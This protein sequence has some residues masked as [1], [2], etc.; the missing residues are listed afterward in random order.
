MNIHFLYRPE[1]IELFSQKRYIL[2]LVLYPTVQVVI[3]FFMSIYFT[4][5][6]DWQGLKLV[7]DAMHERY[8]RTV[9]RGDTRQRNTP[10]QTSV[11]VLFVYLPYSAVIFFP[12]F[13]LPDCHM[14][15]L[16]PVLTSIFPA[17]DALVIILLI[18][19]K[20][21]GVLRLV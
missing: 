3:W 20:S 1:K 15:E 5:T 16:F 18:K 11:P 9:V 13:G 2:L 6:D 19:V 10:L 7:Q 4:P 21:Y 17:W 12:F 8:D 14:P